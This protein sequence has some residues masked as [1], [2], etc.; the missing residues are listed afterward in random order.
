MP[1]FIDLTSFD[2]KLSGDGVAT[3]S[4]GK[5]FHVECLNRQNSTCSTDAKQFNCAFCDTSMTFCT[6][7]V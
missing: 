6:H 4:C 7:L 5:R 2:L 3:I 1:S